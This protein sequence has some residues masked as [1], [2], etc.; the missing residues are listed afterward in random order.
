MFTP[1]Q[2]FRFR[3]L[4]HKGETNTRVL[5][6]SLLLAAHAALFLARAFV[7]NTA[8]ANHLG[9]KRAL[10]FRRVANHENGPI[11]T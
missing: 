6:A 11:R 8:T 1:L 2:W 4:R 3:S 10:A 9:S 5:L 7:A